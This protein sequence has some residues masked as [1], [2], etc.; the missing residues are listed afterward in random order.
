MNNKQLIVVLILMTIVVFLMSV[1]NLRAAPEEPPL[2]ELHKW[3]ILDNGIVVL[4]YR[5]IDKYGI[6]LWRFRH[7][8][9]TVAEKTPS[10]NEVAVDGDE[11]RLLTQE[12]KPSLYLIKRENDGAVPEFDLDL[13][14]EQW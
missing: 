4:E 2:S 7:A 8:Q 5:I 11:I 1:I 14:Y 10:C 6:Q 3:Y 12:S 9:K 13:T